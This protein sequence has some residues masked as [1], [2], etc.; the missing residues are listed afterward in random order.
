MSSSLGPAWKA[1]AEAQKIQLS[2]T[3]IQRLEA[4]ART[5]L[6][7]RGMIDWSE[8]PAQVFTPTPPTEKP[9]E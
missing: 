9:A 1:I 6:G 5:M 3:S 8:E 7:L 4:I 2:E